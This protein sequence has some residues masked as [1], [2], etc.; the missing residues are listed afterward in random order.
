MKVCNYHSSQRDL[1][2]IFNS[3]SDKIQ[4]LIRKEEKQYKKSYQK[5]NTFLSKYNDEELGTLWKTDYPVYQR[6]K[7]LIK[8]IE[9]IKQNRNVS[10][11]FMDSVEKEYQ[12]SPTSV[13]SNGGVF[14]QQKSR[15]VEALTE[16]VSK[17]VVSPTSTIQSQ[18]AVIQEANCGVQDHGSVAS[19]LSI[20]GGRVL[21]QE[22]KSVSGIVSQTSSKKSNE[23]LG[24]EKVSV[25]EVFPESIQQQLNNQTTQSQSCQQSPIHS[26][27]DKSLAPQPQITQYNNNEASPIS[28]DQS[29]RVSFQES[30][31]SSESQS[32][33]TS[34]S[35]ISQETHNEI[36]NQSSQIE[37]DNEDQEFSNHLF[38]ENCLR[39]Q[40]QHL[41]NITNGLY[42]I[43]FV[44]RSTNQLKK[45]HHF[46]NVKACSRSVREIWLCQECDNYLNPEMDDKIAKSSVNVWPAFICST[47]LDPKVIKVYGNTVWKL[48]PQLWRYW[49][50]FNIKKSDP[51]YNDVTLYDPLPAIK[52]ICIEQKEWKSDQQSLFLPNIS[53]SCNKYMMPTVL[54]PWGCTE[55]I[56]SCGHVSLDIM[57]QRFL[58]KV[59]IEMMNKNDV[60]KFVKYCRDDFIRFDDDYDYLILNDEDW[61]VMPSV[62]Y[63]PKKGMQFMVC[64][65]HHG[66]TTNAYI[67]PPRQPNHI[68]PC[69]YSDQICH[70]VIKPRTITQMKAQKY[71]N[72]FQMHEQRGNFNGIDTCNV[73][74]Y[75]DFK[76]LSVLLEEYESRSICGRPDINALLDQFVNEKQISP[77][78]AECY[79]NTARNKTE[80]LNIDKLCYGSTYV[81]TK[82]AIEMQKDNHY[83]KV[84]W[85]SRQDRDEQT[86]CMNPQ[87]P[88]YLYPIQ[89]GNAYGAT[90]T[91]IPLLN[92]TEKNTSMLWVL[93][94]ILSQVEEIWSLV[95]NIKLRQ[96][97][98]HG[99]ILTYI[100]KTCLTHNNSRACKEDP[101]KMTFMNKISTLMEKVVC[102][103]YIKHFSIQWN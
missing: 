101:F 24:P 39:F 21:F 23:I 56:F 43:K 83:T 92:D 41:I 87:F 13:L 61:T 59:N 64:K 85:D 4:R 5:L 103:Q 75:R 89:K 99:W 30:S 44:R 34:P 69:K 88:F 79:R 7:R 48:I 42:K 35:S 84:V 86:L 12:A 81:P 29:G 91:L 77:D 22:D 73:T 54:C 47:L 16:Q 78:T 32:I 46:K 93:I 31:T 68:L 71:S 57:F 60:L 9:K 66:G 67:H 95:A 40:S 20:I 3:M 11:A 63:I 50:L 90:P 53:S 62:S 18:R 8:S 33:E 96:S 80:F 97:N 82:V 2:I 6:Y 25:S 52:D 74:Q 1:Y 45:R 102:V 10:Q 17:V 27:P 76:V 15:P 100:A 36:D 14:S 94:G 58:P 49:W 65:N 38:C 51:V 28:I 70:A 55:F 72:C 37:S 98:W 26:A 19:N